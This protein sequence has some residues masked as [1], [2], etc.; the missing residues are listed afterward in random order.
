MMGIDERLNERGYQMLVVNTAQQ[1]A[2]EIEQ[3]YNLA[4]QKVAGI[5]WLGTTVTARHLSAI[6]AIQIPVLLIGQEHA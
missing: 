3:L 6:E 1:T 2:R 5:I 4:K